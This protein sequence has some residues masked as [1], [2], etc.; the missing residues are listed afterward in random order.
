M[1]EQIA[2]AVP[3]TRAQGQRQL[4]L[5]IGAL[6]ALIRLP[7]LNLRGLVPCAVHVVTSSDDLVQPGDEYIVCE[8]TLDDGQ[9]VLL[10]DEAGEEGYTTIVKTAIPALRA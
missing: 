4:T 8:S 7:P 5:A 9:S 1:R 6:T 2:L 10:G 3:A